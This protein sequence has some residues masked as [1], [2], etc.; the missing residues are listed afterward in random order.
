MTVFTAYQYDYTSK[1]FPELSP[2]HLAFVLLCNGVELSRPS[3]ICEL[4]YGKGVS[5]TVYS[6]ALGVNWFGTDFERSHYCFA[7][8]L[9]DAAGSQCHFEGDAFADYCSR[10]DLPEFDCIIMHG[11]WSWIR[12]DDRTLIVDFIRRRL[13]S[14]GV[15]YLSYNAMPGSAVTQPFGNLL[16][17]I[18]RYESRRADGESLNRSIKA[19]KQVLK[20][21]GRY[22]REHPSAVDSFVSRL[23]K[24]PGYLAHEYLSSD[25][26]AFSF[27]EICD[28]FEPIEDLV[29][30]AQA[31]SSEIT[32]HSFYG[33]RLAEFTALK[34]DLRI[35][36]STR[37]FLGNRGF[38]KDCWVRS[39]RTVSVQNRVDCFKKIRV[40]RVW[41]VD[42]LRQTIS[43]HAGE[44]G[45]QV[46]C[47][48]VIAGCLQGGDIKYFGDILKKV[49]SADIDVFSTLKSLG[50]LLATGCV[51]LVPEVGGSAQEAFERVGRLNEKL[52]S[53][54]SSLSVPDFLVSPVTCGAIWLS[55][56]ERLCWGFLLGR[57]E[58]P[59]DL[60]ALFGRLS[61]FGEIYPQRD[62][63]S[64]DQLAQLACTNFEAVV[65]PELKRLR[66]IPETP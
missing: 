53:A 42:T 12:A 3:T 55:P 38:R 48:H 65:L 52:W 35:S 39:P 1:C 40:T 2:A 8:S 6:A 31:D 47:A 21:G 56:I 61:S 66:C 45:V 59:G 28:Q 17:E 62:S 25:W 9:A 57:C 41:S 11:L 10:S 24:D 33:E 63:L 30:V 5:A 15:L 44:Y 19:L 54:A 32:G 7:K 23:S 50:F 22:C 27:G 49:R 18:N 43:Q 14:G 13:K 34:A 26:R 29:Y 60:D 64:R 4:G 16:R 58:S 20:V 51:A 36:E 46:D 37:D